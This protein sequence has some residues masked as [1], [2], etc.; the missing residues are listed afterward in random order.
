MKR[1][2]F[3]L[4]GL[5][6]IF[7]MQCGKEQI[8]EPET[9]VEISDESITYEIEDIEAYSNALAKRSMNFVNEIRL[10]YFA[11]ALAKEL[12][13]PNVCRLLK[14]EIGKRFDGDYDALWE[15]V[16]D[17][18]IGRRGKFRDLIMK[19]LGGKDALIKMDEIEEVPLLQV[20]CPVNFNKWD[21]ESPVLVAYE[22]LTIDDMEWKEVY[23]YDAEGNEYVLDAW[24]EPEFPVIVVGR[25]ERIGLGVLP[26]K[27]V[28]REEGT[29]EVWQY[30]RLGSNDGDP[31]LKGD[32]EIYVVIA[33]TISGMTSKG[34]E[35]VYD[36]VGRMGPHDS[37]NPG[38]S[39]LWY[40]DSWGQYVG[41]AVLES[42]GGD[43]NWTISNLVEN[44]SVKISN[45]GDDDFI[46]RDETLI[47]S[48]PES[49]YY[50]MGEIRVGF[51]W[52]I[53]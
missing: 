51:I 34:P 29:R 27:P 32:G 23:A 9:A 24:E 16:R 49:Y 21:G 28:L 50:G 6:V 47:F 41:W 12:R 2:V 5:V 20:S 43:Y 8:T 52:G 44:T 11:K 45:T 17:R 4:I 3:L 26:A 30:L 10:K 37:C 46:E 18:K 13:D 7:V 22:I 15:S 39:F 25:N 14:E 48:H 42:D 36:Y 38:A 40:R 31:W 33:G 19:R 53:D 35:Y 1:L